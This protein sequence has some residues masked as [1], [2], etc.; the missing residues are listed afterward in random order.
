[1]LVAVKSGHISLDEHSDCLCTKIDDTNPVPIS[2]CRTGHLIA[3]RARFLQ[4]H[5][6]MEKAVVSACLYCTCRSKSH[7]CGNGINLQ[8]LRMV[9]R[10][11][12]APQIASDERDAIY[13][14]T[15]MR[16]P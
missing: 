1:M 4:V 16:T 11:V 6:D 10:G 7:T 13:L 9:G 12:Q 14:L 15:R 8:T 3:C 2:A 5:R